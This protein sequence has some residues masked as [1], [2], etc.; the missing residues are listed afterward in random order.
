MESVLI[1]ACFFGIPCRY[2]GRKKKYR[3]KLIE[4]LSK[5]YNLIPVCPEV[6]GGLPVPREPVK[7]E[8]R[9]VIGKKT[10]KDYTLSFLA[11]SKLT[12]LIANATKSERAYFKKGS[13]SCDKNGIAGKLLIENNIKVISIP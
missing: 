6:L 3:K 11:G 9:K 5:R 7:L 8:N 2:H 4:K 13:P 1:S 10:G 12:L